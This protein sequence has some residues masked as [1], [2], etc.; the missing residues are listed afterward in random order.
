MGGW[1]D[2][3]YRISEP[4]RPDHFIEFEDLPPEIDPDQPQ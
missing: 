3:Q 4:L 1:F 2:E